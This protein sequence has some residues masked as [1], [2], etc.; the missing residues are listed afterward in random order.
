MVVIYIYKNRFTECL[1]IAVSGFKNRHDTR[2]GLGVDKNRFSE[3][4]S[5]S[6]TRLKNRPD[7]RRGMVW[8]QHKVRYVWHH[9]DRVEKYVGVGICDEWCGWEYMLPTKSRKQDNSR[10]HMISPELSPGNE[11]FCCVHVCVCVCVCVCF[12]VC[13]RVSSE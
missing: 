3:F 2:K 13:Q 11:N 8:Y 9:A 10:A 6:V 5:I 12:C 1:R 4:L 7:N